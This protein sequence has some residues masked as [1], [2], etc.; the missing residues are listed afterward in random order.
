[1]FIKF[2]QDVYTLVKWI[3]VNDLAHSKLQ[4]TSQRIFISNT[5]I[6]GLSNKFAYMTG[7][8]CKVVESHFTQAGFYLRTI[9]KDDES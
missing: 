3:V 7:L 6:K 9:L 5:T 4:S 2:E 8:E 1:M